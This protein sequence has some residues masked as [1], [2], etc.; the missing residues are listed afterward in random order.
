MY[1]EIEKDFPLKLKMLRL[2]V[3]LS[4]EEFAKKNWYFKKLSGKLRNGKTP[5]G[6]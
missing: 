5:A 4:Q 3:G 1:K 6:Y 2:D